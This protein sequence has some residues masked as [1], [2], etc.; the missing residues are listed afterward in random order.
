MFFP[1]DPAGLC[2][3]TEEIPVRSEGEDAVPIHC[4]RGPGTILGHGLRRIGAGPNFLAGEGVEA[5]DALHEDFLTISGDNTAP[6]SVQQTV[7]YGD[8]RMPLPHIGV[9]EDFGAIPQGFGIP[10]SLSGNAVAVYA[11]PA[12]PILRSEDTRSI[13]HK[14]GEKTNECECP[15]Q[16]KASGDRLLHG[17]SSVYLITILLYLD[18]LGM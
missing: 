3:E 12:G 9:P 16:E 13:E 1:Q 2:I 6:L 18:F 11:P 8:G 10:V 4:G 5:V 14:A 15:N 17:S 7:F